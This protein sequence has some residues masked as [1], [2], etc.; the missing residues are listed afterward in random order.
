[1]NYRTRALAH[2]AQAAPQSAKLISISDTVASVSRFFR[3]SLFSGLT[4]FALVSTITTS[5]ILYAQAATYSGVSG[6]VT[7]PSGTAISDAT[8]ELKH[9]PTGSVYSARPQSNGR[10]NL[11]GLRVGGPYVLTVTASGYQTTQKRDIYLELAKE[12][13]VNMSLAASTSDVVQLEAFVVNSEGGLTIF[14]GG[15]T[16]TGSLI[17][18]QRVQDTATVSRS[19]TDFARLDP[20]VVINDTDR[21]EITAA[22]QNNRNNSIQ[23]DGVNL[24]DQFGLESNGFSAIRNPISIDTIEE[25]SVDIAPY[26]VRQSGFTGAAINAVTKSGTNT[27]KGTAY[28]YYTDDSFR[29]ENPQTGIAEPF[30]EST[31][32]MTLGGPILKD[33]LF[34]FLNYEK[35]DRTAQADDPGFTPNSGDIARIVARATALGFDPGTFTSVSAAQEE[36]KILAKLDWHIN[37]NHRL[38]VRYDTNEGQQPDFGEYTDFSSSSPETALTSHFFTDDRK[39]KTVVAQLYSFWT[40]SLQSQASF[41]TTKIDKVPALSE[42]LFPEIEVRGVSGTAQNGSA[43][44]RGEVFFGTEDSRQSNSLNSE[45]TN[46][47]VNFDYL[48]DDITYSFGIDSE[49]SKFDNLFLQD[50]FGNY[51]YTSIANFE[52]DTVAFGNRNFGIE[53]QSVAAQSDFTVTG[54]Y[55]QAKWLINNQLTV[56]GGIRTDVIQTDRS[57][58]FAQHFLDAFG[59]RNDET[60]GGKTVVAPRLSFNYAPDFD[61]GMQFRGGIGLFQGRAPAVYLSNSFSNN[62]VT[63]S[64]ARINAGT[65]SL[66]Q[67]LN[68]QLSG[69]D[70]I[71]NFDPADPR[72]DLPPGTPGNSVNLIEKGLQLPAVWRAN[73]AIDK[74]LDFMGLIATAEFV[75]TKAEADLF[76]DDINLNPIGTAPD[77]RALFGGDPFRGNGLNP[78]FSNAYRLRNSDG[79]EAFNASIGVSK[80]STG[81][82][83]GSAFYVFGDSNDTSSVTSSTAFSNYVNR[84]VFNQNTDEIGTSNYEIKHRIIANVGYTFKWFGERAPT[85]ISMIYDGRTGRPY[86]PTFS[87]DANGDGTDFNDLIYIPTGPNDPIVTFASAADQSQFFD[88]V[89]ANGLDAYAGSYAPRNSLRSDW[90]HRFDIKFVQEFKFDDRFKTEFFLDMIN[91]GNLLNDEWGVVNQV[92]FNYTDDVVS[93]TIVNDQYVYSYD[94]PSGPTLQTP[95]SRWA[96]QFGVKLHF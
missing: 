17:N 29:A 4:A 91:V 13:R 31:W 24:N 38:S 36:E 64:S 26:D 32:G 1:M 80:P 25:F 70:A 65:F 35:F 79:S 62:G 22:G 77:G 16:G 19:L 8:V 78:A 93:A 43:T 6:T 15:R 51:V 94:N 40:D 73:F 44:S 2:T 18:N 89:A 53:G 83:Y 42:P 30:D 76:V 81:T 61:E 54:I 47:K 72:Q 67:A 3:S 28:Y 56:I 68:G 41:S 90:V 74:K 86:S 87:S 23:V 66:E 57:P 21:G 52:N 39:V 85:R 10:F 11:Q 49:E 82:W 46:I 58:P 48:A 63:T 9:E 33:T 20:M 88:Y 55:G 84:A 14:D 71:F 96:V 12:S 34:F 59:V 95:L 92:P 45:I 50:T 37:R 69:S 75:F 5:P 7:G 27:F 60:I